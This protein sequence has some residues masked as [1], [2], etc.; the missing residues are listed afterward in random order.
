MKLITLNAWGG[1][2]YE[3]LIEFIEKYKNVDIFCLQDVLFG[4]EPV[5]SEAE[6]G[7]INLFEEIR[8]K[9]TEHEYIISKEPGHS[10]INGE[11]LHED[12]G[13]GKVIFYSKKFKIIEKGEFD[14]SD[15]NLT[16]TMVSS[17]CQW[18]EIGID[19]KKY[20]ILNLHG[21]WQKGSNKKDTEERVEQSK[22]INAFM[23]GLPGTKIL[24][25]DFNM[26]P[27]GESMGILDQGMI[28]LIKTHNIETTRNKYYPR[29]EK[30][31]DY[32]LVSEDLKVNEF[33]VLPDEVSDHCA[34]Y[35][36]FELL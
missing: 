5:F 26:V 7:R 27:D 35:L 15:K 20:T 36:D 9:L 11:M 28:N 8:K 12:I 14:V 1:K 34:L 4:K 31:A 6:K 23:K 13:S 16:D 25:G 30:F 10:F 3:P 17:K 19:T 18:I 2:L 24:A 21:L 22:R 29:G 32:I 33:K